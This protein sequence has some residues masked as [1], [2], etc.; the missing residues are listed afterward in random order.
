VKADASLTLNFSRIPRVEKRRW[1]VEPLYISQEKLVA[2]I[3]IG[4]Q[5][6]LRKGKM[7]IHID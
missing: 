4:L 7:V 1:P 3:Q 2:A 5:T 6:A